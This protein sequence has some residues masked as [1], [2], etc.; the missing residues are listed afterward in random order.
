MFLRVV[1]AVHILWV[2]LLGAVERVEL[3]PFVYSLLRGISIIGFEPLLIGFPVLVAIGIRRSAMPWWKNVL[4]IAIEVV[5]C[6]ES[7]VAVLP[8][9]Q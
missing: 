3:S 1:I 7:F 6:L 4:V 8:G 5:L 9:V 2:V